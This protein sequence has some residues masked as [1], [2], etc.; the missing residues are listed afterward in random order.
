[1]QNLEVIKVLLDKY[2]SGE[3]TLEEERA[4]KSYFTGPAVAEQ[5]RPMIPLFQTLRQ[6]QDLRLERSN[7]IPMPGR[8]AG[9]SRWAVAAA[10]AALL[11]VGGWWMFGTPSVEN[12][13]T[14]LP[15]PTPV[16]AVPTPAAP[17]AAPEQTPIP[18]VLVQ[19]APVRKTTV[20]PRKP[21][22]KALDPETEMAMEEIKAALALVSSKLN[23]GKKAAIKDLN[24]LQ[25]VDRFLKPKGIG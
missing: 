17:Q 12:V 6:E 9:R 25:N 23:K 15:P 7:V 8:R 18:A 2:W 13:A 11:A 10:I 19:L 22:P 5:L 3:T 1:M 4:L 16:M 14:T 20:K 24:Q 21:A